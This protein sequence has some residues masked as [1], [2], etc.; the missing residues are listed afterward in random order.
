M[1]KK[2]L[3]VLFPNYSVMPL[4]D[5]AIPFSHVILLNKLNFVKYVTF[6]LLQKNSAIMIFHKYIRMIVMLFLP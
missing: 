5:L 2:S 3:N 1:L 6:Y 4:L